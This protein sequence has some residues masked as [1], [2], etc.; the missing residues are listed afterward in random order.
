MR[1]FLF[2]HFAADFCICA[3]FSS[4]ARNEF[5]KIELCNDMIVVYKCEEMLFIE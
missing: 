1:D 3:S 5:G 4:F 2:V